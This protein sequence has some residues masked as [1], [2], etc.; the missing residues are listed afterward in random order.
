MDTGALAAFI[1]GNEATVSP[2]QEGREAQTNVLRASHSG[3]RALGVTHT[4][5]VR[6]VD[7]E[8][9][10]VIEDK[11]EGD[12]VHDFELN[13]QLAPH[14]NAEIIS[15][16]NGIMCRVLGDSQVELIVTGSV[17]F[18]GEM[19]PSLVSTAY[20]ATVPSSRVRVWGRTKIPVR[21]TT[22]VWW[23]EVAGMAGRQPE[24]TERSQPRDAVAEGVC[25]G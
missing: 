9:S 22:Q 10:F 14:R 2:I 20:G 13:F 7:G 18:Q 24:S 3:Y 4:R 8:S 17:L 19:R 12:G 6:A 16:E 25:R 21:L 11:L 5:T 15:L 23:A 1:L